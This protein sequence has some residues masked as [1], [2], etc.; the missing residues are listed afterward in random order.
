MVTQIQADP[1][2]WIHQVIYHKPRVR[3]Q[4]ARHRERGQ[5]HRLSFAPKRMSVCLGNRRVRLYY[6]Y[7][8]TTATTTNTIPDVHYHCD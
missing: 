2:R 1:T 3:P 4:T 8:P 7:Y 6:Y 5:T